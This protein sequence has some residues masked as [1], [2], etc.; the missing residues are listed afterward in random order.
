VDDSDVFVEV[1]HMEWPKPQDFPG[2]N[3][4]SRQGQRLVEKCIAEVAQLP[5]SECGVI[6]MNPPTL[7]DEEVGKSI[8]A[9][10]Q[11]YLL[12]DLYTRVSGIILANKLIERSGFIKTSPMAI[13][14]IHA[15]KRCDGALERLVQA[16]WKHPRPTGYL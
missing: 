9:S 1:T 3:W 7:I 4:K 13:V 15:S 5:S 2:T 16:L 8:L 6:I 12:P 10:F 14:N 11:A